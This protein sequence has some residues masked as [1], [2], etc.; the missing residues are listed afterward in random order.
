MV[1]ILDVMEKALNGKPMSETDYQLRLF[2]PKIQEKVRE[3]R[4]KYDPE[5]PIPED[6]AL[7]DDLFQAGL[8][9]LVD[10]GAFCTSSG[11]VIS[12]TESEV[13]EAVKRAPSKLYFG[14]GR[15]RKAMVPR[16]V[17]DK[18]PPWCLLGAGGGACSSDRSF[19]TL[20]EGYAEIPETNG[21]TTPAITRVG[22]MRVRPAS[23]LE[24]LAAMRNAVL[25]REACNRVGRQGIPIMN[26]LATAESD[27]AFAAAL[28]PKFGMRQSDAYM[29]CCMDPMKVDF[30]RLNKVA[31]ALSLGGHIGM[32]FGPL[33]GGYSGGPEGTAVSNVA[34]HMM[35]LLAYQSSWLLPFTIHL[36]YVAS[37]PRDMLWVISSM[38]QAISRNT[39]ILSLNLN[40]TTAGPCTPMCL[41]ETTAAVT[42]AVT[43]GLSIESVGVAT[44]KHEDRTTPV[45]PRISAEVGHAVAGMKRKDANE[46]VKKLLAKYESKLDAPPLGKSLYECW[47]A[48]ARKPTKEYRG[49]IKRYKKE[50]AGMGLRVKEEE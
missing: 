10:V 2:A 38:G 29:I 9:L 18:T 47:D 41:Y 46:L 26:S 45:E 42:A 43:A 21:I 8:E 4:I 23:P 37:S 28:H 49:I 15:D 31:V 30:A 19:L 3:Y 13:M 16:K 25:A 6:N 50:V 24:V 1:Q 39:H 48:D 44:N 32:C 27:I 40:Y 11:R 5:H 17:E 35:G 34:H 7:A 33:L 22:G 12:F 14:E 20:V 36:K